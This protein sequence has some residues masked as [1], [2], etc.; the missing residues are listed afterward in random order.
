MTTPKTEGAI[1]VTGDEAG[2][3]PYHAGKVERSGCTLTLKVR[4]GWESNE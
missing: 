2:T 3:A 4:R 1:I